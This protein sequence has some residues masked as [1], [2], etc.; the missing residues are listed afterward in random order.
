MQKPIPEDFGLTME[1]YKRAIV[2]IAHIR[3]NKDC[4]ESI[5]TFARFTISPL[6]ATGMAIGIAKLTTWLFSNEF[7]MKKNNAE[8]LSFVVGFVIWFFF[9][10][11]VSDILDWISYKLYSHMLSTQISNAVYR[12]VCLYE[13]SLRQYQDSVEEYWKSLRGTLFEKEL[14][15]LY[16][17]L[18]YSVRLTKGSGDEGIDLILHKDSKK[19]IV[20]CKGHEKPIGVGVIRDLYG[21]MIHSGAECAVLACPAGFTDGVRKFA[22]GKPIELLSA[23]E[24]VEMAEKA[25][26]KNNPVSLAQGMNV[27]QRQL[28]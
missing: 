15:R 7:D 23:K 12:K 21:T 16:T 11:C 13:E 8:G 17:S 27:G 19:I 10:V 18:G 26:S 9:V 6:V 4:I 24:L 2:Q 22:K 5:N 1:D 14:A 3:K 25:Q 20:Q 28:A